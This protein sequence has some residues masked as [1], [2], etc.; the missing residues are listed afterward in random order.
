[1]QETWPEWITELSADQRALVAEA[2]ERVGFASHAEVLLSADRPPSPL[3]DRTR[4]ARHAQLLRAR[5]SAAASCLLLAPADR[6][7]RAFLLSRAGSLL[8]PL[9]SD[10]HTKALSLAM[11]LA[12][13]SVRV[14]TDMF[15]EAAAQLASTPTDLSSCD[16]L[17]VLRVHSAFAIMSV[18]ASLHGR[19]LSSLWQ[20]ARA[21]A[22]DAGL[23]RSPHLRW[24]F[25]SL[26]A[27]VGE[28][29]EHAAMLLDEQ[30]RATRLCDAYYF[31]RGD[32]GRELYALGAQLIRGTASQPLSFLASSRPATTLRQGLAYITA[33]LRDAHHLG[34]PTKTLALLVLIDDS[35]L[36]AAELHASGQ[37]PAGA[38][39]LLLQVRRLEEVQRMDNGRF[40][41]LCDKLEDSPVKR[42][43][44]QL[45]NKDYQRAGEHILVPHSP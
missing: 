16:D 22:C 30:A 43:I 37:L 5:S 21:E 11:L 15:D 18:A 33:C 24:R 36:L 14:S 6:S 44:T 4:Q 42:R 19:L 35:L 13:T 31:V 38:L 27:W 40:W 9:S 32:T 26:G 29:D 1:M 41:Q 2:M 39:D 28:A 3:R 45:W 34:T 12:N 17:E 10:V 7:L 23:L 25:A 20:S 8:K